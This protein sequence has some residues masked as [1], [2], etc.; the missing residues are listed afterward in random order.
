MG[1]NYSSSNLKIWGLDVGGFECN[2]SL[3]HKRTSTLVMASDMN[4]FMA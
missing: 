2:A 4:Y 3:C 1:G